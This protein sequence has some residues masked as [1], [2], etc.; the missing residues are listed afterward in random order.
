MARVFW[1]TRGK[2][3]DATD[4]SIDRNDMSEVRL[5]LTRGRAETGVDALLRPEQARAAA[6]ELIAQ[7]DA[8]EAKAA[9]ARGVRVTS[10]APTIPPKV[11]RQ[12]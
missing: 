2:R 4:L 7:A 5:R 11:L 6:A 3:E 8:I 1:L 9:E 12:V 10:V